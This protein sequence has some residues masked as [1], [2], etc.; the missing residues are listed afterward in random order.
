MIPATGIGIPHREMIPSSEG[1]P[2]GRYSGSSEP[3]AAIDNSVAS[4]SRR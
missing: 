4:G 2:V 1:N 3:I